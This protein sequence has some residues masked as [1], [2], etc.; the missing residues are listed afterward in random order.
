MSTVSRKAWNVRRTWWELTKL[1]L[2]GG[3][4]Y[5]MYVHVYGLSDDAR[6][7]FERQSWRPYYLDWTDSREHFATLL[8]ESEVPDA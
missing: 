5:G 3:G 2:R 4:G 6:A 7:E 8:A 1:M